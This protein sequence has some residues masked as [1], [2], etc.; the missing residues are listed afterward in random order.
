LKRY[1]GAHPE[2]SLGQPGK[3]QGLNVG[4]V[5]FHLE[6]MRSSKIYNYFLSSDGIRELAL[7]YGFTQTHLGAQDWLT[8]LLFEKENLVFSLDCRYNVQVLEII[9]LIFRVTI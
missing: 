1:I 8:L 6:R 3:F 4:V 5:L 9:D 7:K 2:T